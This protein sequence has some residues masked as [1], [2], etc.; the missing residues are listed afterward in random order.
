VSSQ[1]EREYGS[2]RREPIRQLKFNNL[3]PQCTIDIFTIA[4]D[5]VQTLVHD[6]QDGTETWDLRGAGGRVIAP[7][8]YL[9]RVRTATA[10]I[11]NRFAVI[12]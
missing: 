10:E 3:P 8:V 4:G 1:Y 11:L 2:L 12:K 6:S 9:Y 5:L 7:G